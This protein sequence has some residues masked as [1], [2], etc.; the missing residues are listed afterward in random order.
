MTS[1]IKDAF[2]TAAIAAI[3]ALP[4]A[5]VRTSE[6]MEGLKRYVS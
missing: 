4:L 6:G 3:L 2:F 1:R 5:G